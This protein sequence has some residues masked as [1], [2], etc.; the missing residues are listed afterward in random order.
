MLTVDNLAYTYPHTQTPVFEDLSFEVPQGEVCAVI[1][2]NGC[3][4]TTLIK[5]LTGIFTPQR[6][7]VDIVSPIGYVPQKVNFV[8]DMTVLDAIVMGRYPY[9]GAFSMPK[10]ADYDIA[11]ACADQL[12][13]TELLDK[14]FSKLSGGQQQLVMV[15]RALAVGPH[16]IVFDE[17]CSA[18]DYGNQN[19]ILSIISALKEKQITAV[20]STH[21]PNHALHTADTVL[22][23]QQRPAFM[24]GPTRT[25]MTDQ[26]LSALYGMALQKVNV[27][28]RVTSVVALFD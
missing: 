22:V 7:H 17:P 16:C 19:R 20:F 4:K 28:D 8:Y 2:K 27:N 13:I 15:A 10:K 21:D 25:T 9:I 6:G 1:G 24:F 11:R 5:C 18:L 23:M 26:V 12:T 14:T 3:G